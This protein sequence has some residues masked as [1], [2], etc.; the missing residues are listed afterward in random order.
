MTVRTRWTDDSTSVD[1]PPKDPYKARSERQRLLE[2]AIQL[3]C[4]DRNRTHGDP[5]ENFGR[6][7]ALWNAQFAGRL[8]PGERFSAGDVAIA[9]VLTKTARLVNSPTLEDSWADIAGYAACGYETTQPERE[10]P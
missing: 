10:R 7:A 1:S 5:D 8:A 6:I 4:G 9:M 3:V 2:R